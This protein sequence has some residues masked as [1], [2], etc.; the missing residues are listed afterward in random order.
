MAEISSP[1]PEVVAVRCHDI[2][3]S[4]NGAQVGEFDRLLLVGMAVQLALHLRG[5]VTAVSYDMLR[6][7]G[8]YLL[9]IPSTSF[10]RVVELLADI[11]FL[12][13]DRQGETIRAVVPTI[14]YYEDLFSGVGDFVANRPL[15]EP[16]QL[17]IA[18]LDRL[19]RSP[20]NVQTLY[21]CGAEKRLLQ[22]TLQVGKEGGYLIGRMARGREMLLSP[23][24]FPEHGEAFA[25][26]AAGAGSGTV[27]RVISILA[28][29]QGWPLRLITESGKI[30]ETA[31]TRDEASVVTE[32]A[33]E[34][35]S[36]PPMITTTHAGSNYFIFGP[37]PGIPN[38]P[39]QKRHIYETAMALVAAVRQGQLL[40]ERI[41]I[42]MP[43]ELLQALKERKWLRANT[44][45]F[46]Q[47]RKLVVLRLGRLVPSGNAGWYRFELI[48][49]PENLEAVEMALLLVKGQQLPLAANEEIAIALEKGQQYVESLVSRQTLVKEN[50]VPCDPEIRKEIDNLF[51]KGVP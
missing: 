1:S 19:S 23:V 46:E 41:R 32:L 40:P 11:E 44:E 49:T 17:T 21:T 39:P 4:L 47:Y 51:Y 20:T 25:D 24:Y 33:K 16:E 29:N 8:L 30:G 14:P 34:G 6:Q 9:H 13:V 15:S 43:T 27:A 7:V 5:L 10:E 18:V 42:R 50:A 37:K 3:V 38:L 2:T 36:P 22:R 31:L 35:F 48:D 28:K 26:L 12:K 45:A